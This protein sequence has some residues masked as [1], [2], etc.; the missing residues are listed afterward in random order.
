MRILPGPLARYR[1]R[2]DTGGTA[3]LGYYSQLAWCK[4][5]PV[6]TPGY[7][8]PPLLLQGARRGLSMVV[9]RALSAGAD[10]EKLDAQGWHTP[11]IAAIDGGFIRECGQLLSAG[12]DMRGRDREGRTAMSHVVERND[13]VI[14]SMLLRAGA[15][16]NEEIQLWRP[17][18]SPQRLPVLS[19]AARFGYIHFVRMLLD[20]GADVNGTPGHPETSPIW[21]VVSRSEAHAAVDACK[22]LVMAGADV[23]A[24]VRGGMSPL[25]YAEHYRS[26]LGT[27]LRSMVSQPGS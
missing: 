25:E 27:V 19:V 3:R 21:Q 14:G 15:D 23:H 26:S 8:D 22:L 24:S 11:L 10:V 7:T 9:A 16:P 13:R 20:A 12:A 4:G 1:T 2:L 17:F 5:V 18:L 6:D